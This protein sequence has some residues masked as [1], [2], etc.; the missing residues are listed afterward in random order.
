M[1]CLLVNDDARGPDTLY[2]LLECQDRV[3]VTTRM[4]TTETLKGA[5][6]QLQI[7]KTIDNFQSTK[8]KVSCF[9]DSHT[10]AKSAKVHVQVLASKNSKILALSHMWI[11][12]G[13]VNLDGNYTATSIGIGKVV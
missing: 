4:K 9:K 10:G 6:L 3:T 13:V 11:D 12:V 8:S 2:I 1:G 5:R 7:S